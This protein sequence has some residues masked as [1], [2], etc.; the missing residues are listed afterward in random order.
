[1]RTP[2]CPLCGWPL[3]IERDEDGIGCDAICING[4]C[5]EEE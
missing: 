5:Y 2:R 1:M 4:G 3:A